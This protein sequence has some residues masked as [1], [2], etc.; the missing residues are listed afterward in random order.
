MC[1]SNRFQLL[2][3]VQQCGPIEKFDVLFH[4]SGPQCGQPR[5]YAFVTYKDVSTYICFV[6]G[7]QHPRNNLLPFS[8]SRSAT[9]ALD[10]LHGHHVGSK[11]M[12]VRMAKNINYVRNAME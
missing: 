9:R 11:T 4:K 12:V 6:K 10:K 2:K 8:Q 1:S 3:I 5:G 7:H